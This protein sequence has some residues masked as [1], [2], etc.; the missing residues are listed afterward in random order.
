MDEAD[1]QDDLES[2]SSTCTSPQQSLQID[3]DIEFDM[4][5]QDD[6]VYAAQGSLSELYDMS[7]YDSEQ[8]SCTPLYDGA[9]LS[10]MDALVKY[11]KWFS[12]H[13]GISK[14]ALSDILKL[15]HNEVLPRGNILPSSFADAMKLVE[16][17]LIQPILFHACPNDCLIFRNEYA[18]LQVC[19]VCGASRYTKQGTPARRFTYLPVGPRLVRLFGTKN[20]AEIVQ[21]HGLQQGSKRSHLYDIHDSTAWKLVYST[22]GQ[23]ASEFRSISFAFNTDRFN[24]Y[25]QN[26][27]SY[28]MWPI[29]LTV[30]NFPRKVRYSHSNFWLVGTIPGNGSKE[31]HSV[32]PYLSVLVDELLEITNKVVFDSYQN[33]PFNLKVDILLYILDYKGVGKVFNL[34]G[35]NAYQACAWCDLEGKT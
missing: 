15:E 1:L 19:P 25:S 16:P 32:D 28:S 5:L 33:A 13:P 4:P 10:L 26:R 3:G 9:S 8:L 7:V 12:E 23:F 11:L 31:P 14:E 6:S 2:V 20:L 27:V 35:P 30:L 34:M 17:F 22:T 18:H 24:P 29:I 21:S